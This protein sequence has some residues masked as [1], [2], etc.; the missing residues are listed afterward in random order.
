MKALFADDDEGMR[1]LVEHILKDHGYEVVLAT[2]GEEALDVFSR[3]SFDLVLLD[4]MM[5][6]LNGYEACER[7]RAQNADV[8]IILV[9]AK[10]DIVDKS[11]G[12]K[13]GADDYVVKPFVPQELILR[14]D[15]LMRRYLRE[16]KHT[17][18]DDM[19]HFENLEIDMVGHRAIANGKTVALTPK[20]FELLSI[21]ASNP[22][23][24]FS[25]KQL[26]ESIWGP[27]CANE[28]TSITV[29]VHRLRNKIEAD[30]SNPTFVKT[31]YHAGY[32][33]GVS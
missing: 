25:S 26:T 21:L 15:A 6:G 31:A 19:L 24:A 29:L 11:M 10:D 20:E 28:I 33:L 7:L 17:F 2:N 8:P 5:P 9:T 30:P 14:I 1:T 27:D 16:P 4:V 32:K 12:F 3:D 22:G 13:M 23:Q 18:N